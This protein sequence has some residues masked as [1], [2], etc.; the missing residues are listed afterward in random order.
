MIL[1]MANRI[2]PAC[3]NAISSSTRSTRTGPVKKPGFPPSL[4][5]DQNCEK[6]T[7]LYLQTTW[8]RQL[9]T[10]VDYI[11][12]SL[13]PDIYIALSMTWGIFR[14]QTFACVILVTL[15]II[16]TLPL[17]FTCH[18]NISRKFFIT[19]LKVC[20]IILGKVKI[21]FILEQ[22]MKGLDAIWGKA[23]GAWRWPPTPI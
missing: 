2:T 15:L 11:T 20:L 3:S 13:I 7:L 8:F 17:H 12:T 14:H 1:K 4:A 10:A 21:K 18:Q 19:F 22:A 9:R 16:H 5:G 23:A 6:V